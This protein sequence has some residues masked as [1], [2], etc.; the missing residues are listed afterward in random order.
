MDGDSLLET[1]RDITSE[2]KELSERLEN[3]RSVQARELYRQSID[4]HMRYLLWSETKSAWLDSEVDQDRLLDSIPNHRR[5]QWR[6]DLEDPGSLA[7]FVGQ[8]FA[9]C[10]DVLYP[11]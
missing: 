1:L 3:E 9:D 6:M 11:K 5:T 8:F 4:L 10:D 7:R 2:L